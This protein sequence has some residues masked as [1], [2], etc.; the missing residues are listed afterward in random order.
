MQKCSKVNVS[1]MVS[2]RAACDHAIKKSEQHVRDA[3]AAV[4]LPE[5]TGGS[6]KSVLRSRSTR[7][8]RAPH[9][10]VLVVGQAGGN[11]GQ[12]VVVEV[13]LA[14][15]GH[16]SQCSILHGADLV[17]AQ[18]QSAGTHSRREDETWKCGG[19]REHKVH[20]WRNRDRDIKV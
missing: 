14:Q 4:H 20:V 5:L 17:V 15:V 1:S 2:I 19:T 7:C 12:S 11:A 6:N 3:R 13:Q 9:L 8:T 10:D 16:V 18:A